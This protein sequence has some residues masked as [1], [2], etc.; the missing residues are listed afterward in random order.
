MSAV[1]NFRSDTLG[2]AGLS[3][4]ALLVIAFAA[5]MQ[6]AEASK[7][8][9]RLGADVAGDCKVREALICEPERP[10][11]IS[12]WWTLLH[13]P[14]VLCTVALEWLMYGSMPS[15]IAV[16]ADASGRIDTWL[17][18]GTAMAIPIL[19]QLMLA[20]TMAFLGIVICRS[21]HPVI[22][23]R[24]VSSS[25]AYGIFAR[26]WSLLLLVSGLSLNTAIGCMV[27]VFRGWLTMVGFVTFIVVIVC[28]FVL[29]GVLL[30]VHYG[31]NGSHVFTAVHQS[32]ASGETHCRRRLF[33]YEKGDP[34][35][36]VPRSFGTGW[37]LN[38]ARPSAWLLIT[39]FVT[40]SATPLIIIIAN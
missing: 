17:P 33:Y 23:G 21:K 7:I 24:G 27:F 4:S 32:G 39:V 8:V 11:A 26:A 15:G 19:M 34:S 16:H 9:K 1:L 35:V 14:V 30:S 5:V 37:G 22:T 6:H 36:F 28:A 18:K 31:Q 38:W 2:L 10:R 25:Y 29:G 20:G 3:V 12:P 13:I 40:V